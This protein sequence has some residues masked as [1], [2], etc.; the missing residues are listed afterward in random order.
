MEMTA[1]TDLSFLPAILESSLKIGND[2]IIHRC[3]H[4]IAP[5][6]DGD[7]A[8]CV[9]SQPSGIPK[10]GN[11]VHFAVLVLDRNQSEV[12]LITLSF[13]FITPINIALPP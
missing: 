11:D 10:Q 1:T 6:A 2:N 13:F 5:I 9:H 4:D 8:L 12:T 7:N 3:L